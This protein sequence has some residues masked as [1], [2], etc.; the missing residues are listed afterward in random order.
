MRYS[1]HDNY[2]KREEKIQ[3]ESFLDKSREGIAA[4]STGVLQKA[5]VVSR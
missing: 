3:M 5:E 2:Q 4:R 1:E